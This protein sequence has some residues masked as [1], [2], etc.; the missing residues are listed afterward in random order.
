MVFINPGFRELEQLKG[1]QQFRIVATQYKVAIAD[2]EHH[3]HDGL[4]MALGLRYNDRTNDRMLLSA[5]SSL[6]IKTYQKQLNVTPEEVL[7]NDLA[8][9]LGA[10]IRSFD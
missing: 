7:F 6:L 5:G 1:I 3:T 9:I 10:E 4:K 2:A 8:S